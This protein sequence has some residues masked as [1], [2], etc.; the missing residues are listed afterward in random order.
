MSNRQHQAEKSSQ[1]AEKDLT[2]A[3]EWTKHGDPKQKREAR[4]MA[5]LAKRRKRKAERRAAKGVCDIWE[6]DTTNASVA[7]E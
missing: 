5:R 6:L 4:Q 3:H 1:W 7:Q 2:Q